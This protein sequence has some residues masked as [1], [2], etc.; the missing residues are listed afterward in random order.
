LKLSRRPKRNAET[1]KS[2]LWREQRDLYLPEIG[3]SLFV[4]GLLAWLYVVTVQI[5]HPNWLPLPLTHHKIPPLNWRV[6]DV[7]IVSFAVAGFG[8]FMW[9]IERKRTHEF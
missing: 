8:F 2:E 6:D 7:G 5:T 3:L 9:L 1:A 4:F